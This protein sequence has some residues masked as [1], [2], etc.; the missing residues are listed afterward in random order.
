MFTVLLVPCMFVEQGEYTSS[1]LGL[2]LVKF[3]RRHDTCMYIQYNQLSGLLV[4][5]CSTAMD[6]LVMEKQSTLVLPLYNYKNGMWSAAILAKSTILSR[7]YRAAEGGERA[8]NART[9]LVDGEIQHVTKNNTSSHARECWFTDRKRVD[10]E[11]YGRLR[12][13]AREYGR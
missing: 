7:A 13:S 8:C 3:V 10:T 6:S 9:P 1:Q 5:L 4:E 12:A 11:I 2:W